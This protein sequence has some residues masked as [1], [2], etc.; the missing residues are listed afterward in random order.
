MVKHCPSPNIIVI[1]LIEII[2]CSTFFNPFIMVEPVLDNPLVP[3]MFFHEGVD[4]ILNSNPRSEIYSCG[5][6]LKNLAFKIAQI[7]FFQEQCGT[8]LSSSPFFI[9]FFPIIL[10]FSYFYRRSRI[11]SED[12]P[13]A[14]P[15]F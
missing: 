15:N 3:S 14:S 12:D 9:L 4:L 5:N 13:M 6:S 11:S 1:L 7:S 10:F 8:S 2:F